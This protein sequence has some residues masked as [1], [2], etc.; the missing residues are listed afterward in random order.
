LAGLVNGTWIGTAASLKNA[1]YTQGTISVTSVTGTALVGGAIGKV[2]F[3]GS[4]ANCSARAGSL[5]VEKTDTGEFYLGGFVGDFM[6]GSISG[7]YTTS[8]VVA[9]NGLLN[10][11]GSVAAGGFVGRLGGLSTATVTYCYATGSVSAVSYYHLYAGGF[12]GIDSTGSISYCYA[13]GNVSAINRTTASRYTYA[14]GFMGS[15]SI[16]SSIT[17]C[18]ALGNV[19]LDSTSSGVVCSGG[20]LGASSS[21]V[22]RCFAAGSVIAQRSVSLPGYTWA[23]GFVGQIGT[24]LISNSAALGASVTLTGPGVT[25]ANIGRVYG[26]TSGTVSNNHAYNGMK[27]Y[28]SATYGD[29]NPTA[30]T[31]TSSAGGKDG[32]DAHLG[33]LRDRT[34]WETTL[35]F[36]AANW[37]FTTVEGRG[38]P[39]LRASASGAI[40]GGQ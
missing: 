36:A 22:T 17:D 7:C 40:M 2:F 3:N 26:T 8:P 11:G 5:N 10:T 13:A 33:I 18:Y 28:Y 30:T 1:A 25:T 32:Q 37:S 20:F 34:F 21:P 9:N 29:P 4:F 38:Y 12:A 19:F 16:F 39:V 14:G 6:A 35:G 15:K 31:P 23:G 24:I 27:L